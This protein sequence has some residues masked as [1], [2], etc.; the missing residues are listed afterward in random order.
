MKMGRVSP[1]F[2]I[3]MA[4]LVVLAIPLV[5]SNLFGG[6]KY[7]DLMRRHEIEFQDKA[8]RPVRLPLEDAIR[9]FDRESGAVRLGGPFGAADS[10]RKVD[11]TCAQTARDAYRITANCEGNA[12]VFRYD[13]GTGDVSALNDLAAKLVPRR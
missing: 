8:G 6:Q 1:G 7:I 3:A 5:R 4:L 9:G 13:F 10:L 12:F 11:W 2:V